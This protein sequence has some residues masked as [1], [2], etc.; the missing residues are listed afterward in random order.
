ME[1]HI[2]ETFGN[3]LRVRASGLYWQDERLLLVNHA[4]L[5]RPSFWAPPGGEILF[6][7][8]AGHTVEREFLEETHLTVKCHRY[9]FAGEFINSPLHAVELFFEVLHRAGNIR[10]GN[11][12]E[13]ESRVIKE[14]RLFTWPEILALPE[15]EKHGLFRYVT[16][17]D[18]LKNLTGFYRF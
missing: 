2:V 11:D 5:G 6:G 14:V 9:L 1:K 8:T 18:D 3:R 4:G 12:P 16:S 10:T 15:S 7:Q 17:A 13:T